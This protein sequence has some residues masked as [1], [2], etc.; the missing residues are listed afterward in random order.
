MLGRRGHDPPGLRGT[1]T[2]NTSTRCPSR[3]CPRQHTKYRAWSGST[4]TFR[5]ASDTSA[6]LKVCLLQG[7]VCLGLTSYVRNGGSAT[8][9]GHGGTISGSEDLVSPPFFVLFS[10]S[11]ERSL[12]MRPLCVTT[13]ADGDILRF[14]ISCANDFVSLFLLEGFQ[15]AGTYSPT[16]W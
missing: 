7:I 1:P 8:T 5:K 16:P 13:A 12:L 14:G 11:T 2:A 9:R 4:L 10:I 3:L 6:L 15:I